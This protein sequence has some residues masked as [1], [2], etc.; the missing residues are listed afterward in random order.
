MHAEKSY[1][2]SHLCVLRLTLP[3]MNAESC[4]SECVCSLHDGDAWRTSEKIVVFVCVL[5]R[6][7][8]HAYLL[9]IHYF[10]RRKERAIDLATFDSKKASAT[11]NFDFG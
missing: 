9:E 11:H 10:T 2:W 4:S 7:M 5:L 6:I 3:P 1:R 8:A